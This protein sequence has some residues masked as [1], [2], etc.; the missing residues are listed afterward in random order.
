MLLQLQQEA[1]YQPQEG[2]E[3]EHLFYIGEV[4]LTAIFSLELVGFS[5]SL[6]LVSR[7]SGERL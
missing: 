2:S 7:K 6:P 3:S 4:V 1:Q 5:K